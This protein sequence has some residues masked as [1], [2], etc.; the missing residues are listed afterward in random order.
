MERFATI[1][2]GSYWL[3]IVADLSILNVSESLGYA[4]QFLKFC[5]VDIMLGLRMV[6]V[7]EKS[8]NFSFCTRN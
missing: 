4:F 1:V 6:L 2:N 3:T 5:F 8:I 7:I